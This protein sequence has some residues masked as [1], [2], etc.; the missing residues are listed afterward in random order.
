MNERDQKTPSSTSSRGLRVAT[1]LR[2]GRDRV[3]KKWQGDLS[4]GMPFDGSAAQEQTAS[5]WKSSPRAR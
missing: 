1:D 2:A 4:E 3:P 5:A